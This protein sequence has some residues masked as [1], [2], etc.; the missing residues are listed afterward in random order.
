[1][2]W[3]MQF[4]AFATCDRT[5]LNEFK[6]K[7]EFFSVFVFFIWTLNQS[8]LSDIFKYKKTKKLIAAHKQAKFTNKHEAAKSVTLSFIYPNKGIDWN[9]INPI[10]LFV[11]F[12][13]IETYFGFW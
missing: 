11:L 3:S 8:F 2:H 9:A 10:Q 12:I 6:N 5:E 13:K 1:M 4:I 7:I